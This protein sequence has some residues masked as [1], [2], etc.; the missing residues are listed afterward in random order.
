MSPEEIENLKQLARS[1]GAK[2]LE[3]DG[4][5]IEFDDQFNLIKEP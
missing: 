1:L 5:T 2:R 4:Q 3:I